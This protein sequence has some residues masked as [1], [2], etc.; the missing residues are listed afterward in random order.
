MAATGVVEPMKSNTGRKKARLL[1]RI[2]RMKET[3]KSATKSPRVRTAFFMRY[4]VRHEKAVLPLVSFHGEKDP[5]M[6]TLVIGAGVIGVA[7]AWALQE[8]GHTVTLVDAREAPGRGACYANGAQISVSHP[9]PWSSPRAPLIALESLTREDGPFRWRPALDTA[10]WCWLTAFLREC[11]PSRHERNTRAIALLARH[12]LQVLRRWREAL[13][14]EYDVQTRGILHL[15][16]TPRDWETG[17]R[18]E[19]ELR[20]LGIAARAISPA[21][22]AEIE[23]ALAP[24]AAKLCGALYAPEDESGDARRFCEEMV[25]RLRQAG[26]EVLFETRW[27][28]WRLGKGRCEAARFEGP[29][30]AFEL[31]AEAIVVCAG[32][33]SPRLLAP[34]GME[35]PI[36]PVKGYSLT[37]PILAPERAPTASL[38][39]ESKRIV[40][41]RLG[42]RLRFAGTAEIAGYDDSV[43]PE[44]IA[45]L[46]RWAEVM[47]PGVADLEAA[48]AWAGL[49][50]MTPSGVPLIGRSPM[51]NVWVNTGH[52][53][54]GWTL[55]CGSAQA[56]LA[57]LEGKTPPGLEAFPF[58]G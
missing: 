11:L 28:G 48:E 14:L 25:A 49:R 51:A 53:S 38:T 10:Q 56:L 22:A 40:C 23:P 41:S 47:L 31:T 30:G 37:A 46:K 18:H 8:A 45:P 15:F 4:T 17:R 21:E 16:F 42:N 29:A 33:D 9:H 7:T 26:A 43:R 55:A 19:A 2:P 5:P 54:L 3:S 13:G 24:V 6:K 36:Y 34:L 1:I 52:G 57:R 58:V 44:R 50:P 32:V 39:D 20:E 27:S 35:A 12:S